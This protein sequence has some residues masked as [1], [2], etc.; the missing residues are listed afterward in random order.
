MNNITFPARNCTT[1]RDV[2]YFG[3]YP[4]TYSGI[5]HPAA[6]IDNHILLNLIQKLRSDT[7]IQYNSVLINYYGSGEDH[8]NW[9]ADDES[10][11]S[12]G[13]SIASLSLG[14]TRIFEMKFK[15]Q[16]HCAFSFELKAG[17][18]L[19]MQKHTQSFFNHRIPKQS[20]ASARLNLTFRVMLPEQ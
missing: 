5:T 2:V 11:M 15:K 9:H 18:L 7:G 12:K 17:S 20:Y 19:V 6:P 13:S 16:E 1:K 10:C 8:I 14:T 3:E 4:Y